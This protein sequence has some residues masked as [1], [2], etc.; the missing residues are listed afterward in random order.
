MRQEQRLSL[1][2]WQPG[3]L[4]QPLGGLQLLEEGYDYAWLLFL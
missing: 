1:G 4:N 2:L 3:Q